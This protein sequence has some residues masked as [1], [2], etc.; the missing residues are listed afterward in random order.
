MRTQALP[1]SRIER[2]GWGVGSEVFV[3]LNEAQPCTQ[4]VRDP[5]PLLIVCLGQLQVPSPLWA[6]ASSSLSLPC[7]DVQSTEGRP[8]GKIPV[9]NR[10]SVTNTWELFCPRTEN[11]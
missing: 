5:H 7:Q 11:I 8:V 2:D 3:R 1:S 6:S 9:L 10:T 4:G